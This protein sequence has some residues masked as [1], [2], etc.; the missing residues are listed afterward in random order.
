MKLPVAVVHVFLSVFSRVHFTTCFASIRL[1]V[2]P[3]SNNTHSTL[4]LPFCFFFCFAH[5][6]L[7]TAMTTG[8]TIA[9]LA[10]LGT[11]FVDLDVV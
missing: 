11:L 3:E 10:Y 7:T 5:I 6:G 4:A 9:C 1:L 8:A 2:L